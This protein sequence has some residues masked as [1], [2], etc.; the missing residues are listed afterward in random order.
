MS[1]RHKFILS[2]GVKFCGDCGEERP[3]IEFPSNPCQSSGYGAYCRPHQ[4][5]RQ[6][7]WANRTYDDLK[8]KVYDR[9]GRKCKRCGFSDER[10]LQIDHV[11]G[12]GAKDLDKWAQFLRKVLNAPDGQ[13][14]VLCANCNWIKRIEE[15]LTGSPRME[16]MEFRV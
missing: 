12:D 15:G 16:Q 3:L 13:Y 9:Y 1:K 6:R 14:Q 4:N 8:K 7:I 5:Q 10:V 2:S 11:N